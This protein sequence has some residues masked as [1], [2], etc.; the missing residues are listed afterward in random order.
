VTVKVSVCVTTFNRAPLLDRTLS[1]LAAQ[2]RLP[3][4]IVVSDDCSPDDTASVVNAWRPRFRRVVYHRNS[5]NLYMPGN[6]NQAVSLATGEYVANL[7]D[8]D[9]FAPTL[10]E[11]WERALDEHPTAGFVCCGVAGF[12][13]R[14][15]AETQVILHDVDPLTPGR[16]FL[17][18]HLLHRFSS[19]VWGTVMARRSAYAELLPFDARFGFISD[20]D[21]WLR[22]CERFDVAYVRE[23]LIVLD[24]SPTEE[25]RFDWTTA[26]QARVMRLE[27]I[28]SV[29]GNTPDRLHSELR[30][31]RRVARLYYLRRILG[32][33]RHGDWPAAASGWRLFTKIR[34]EN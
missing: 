9:E 28:R 7:H 6:L 10:L 30:K 21:M 32:R 19:I 18:R 5:E 8:A 24:N 14:G 26:E 25:R 22:M 27:R 29:F 3:D 4:E 33:L 31:H 17:E 16:V 2:S 23:P 20:V 1:S 11:K 15:T 34:S 13:R 12:P